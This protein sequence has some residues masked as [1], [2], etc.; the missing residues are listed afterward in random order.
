MTATPTSGDCRHDGKL[1]NLGRYRNEHEAG[2]AYNTG[3]LLS[4]RRQTGLNEIGET[5][6]PTPERQVKIREEVAARL[7][8]TF[9][10]PRKDADA[11]QCKWK[12]R[13]YEHAKGF[14]AYI[15]CSSRSIYLGDY[16]TSAQAVFAFSHAESLVNGEGVRQNA[17]PQEDPLCEADRT[18]IRQCVEAAL[19]LRGLLECPAEEKP[20]LATGAIKSPGSC[21]ANISAFLL[22]TSPAGRGSHVFAT[23]ASTFIWRT[24]VTGI[25]PPTR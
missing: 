7:A 10:P 2:F 15:K 19:K 25:R 18:L 3:V 13:H 1:R 8:G 21:G 11:P 24:T 5:S 4:G 6:L 16:P 22:F 12:G 20:Q 9:T 14:C 17:I 23:T